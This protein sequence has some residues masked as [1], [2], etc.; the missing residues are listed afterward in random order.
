[1]AMHDDEIEI[2]DETA[3]ELIATQFPQW[4]QQPVR[5]IRSSGTVNAIFRIGEQYAARFPLLGTDPVETQQALERE[6]AASAEFAECSPFPAPVP[7]GLG[8]PGFGY[9][10]PWSVQTWLP[11]T[12]ATD[13]DPGN[14]EGFARD[15]ATLVAALRAVDTRGRTFTGDNR[16]GHL[17]DHDGWVQKCLRNSEQLLDVRHLA[18]LWKY[19]RDLPRTSPDVMTHGDLIPA[20]VLVDGGRLTGVLDC[21]GFAPA[22]PALDVIAGWHLL[23]D[24]PRSVFRAEL[25]CDDLEWERSKAWAFEQAMGAIW[26]YVDTNPAMTRMGRRALSRVVA[27]TPL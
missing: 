21:G 26:Y 7:V 6:A 25:R 5:R 20:N 17:S 22:D 27:A 24:G 3:R 14:S 9:P 13:A 2:S 1:M 10:L 23:D 12:I 18:R 15:L 8:V 16:G 4:A 19:F 11:G